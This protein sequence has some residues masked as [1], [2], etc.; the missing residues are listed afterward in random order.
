MKSYVIL[1]CV[2]LMLSIVIF[3]P[4]SLNINHALPNIIDPLFYAWN[5]SHNANNMFGGMNR[6]LN[7]NIFYPLTNTLA[8]SD[9][10]WGQSI[11]TNPIIWLTDNPILAENVAVLISFPLAAISMYLL[12]LYLTRNI[13]ASCISGIFFAFSYPRLSQIGHLPT[14]SS[15]WL[16]LYILY[17]FK[18]LDEGKRINF[19]LLC[20]WYTLSIASSIY[21]G[22]F[23]IPITIII[24]IADFFKRIRT[25]TFY[26]Y[27]NRIIATF[28]SIIFFL[29]ILVVVVF[30]YIRLRVESPELKRSIDDMTHL[31]AAPIDYISIL[32][33]SLIASYLPKRM[34]EHVLYP[35]L[36]VITLAFLGIILTWKRNRYMIVICIAIAVSSVVLS[37]GNERSFSLGSFSTGTLKLPYYYLYK[38]FPILQAVRVPARFGI[39]VILSLS[40]L[41]AWGI[42][43]IM[44]Q[45]HSRWIIGILLCV[46]IIEIWQVNTPFVSVPLKNSIPD[47]YIW[48]RQQ[49]EPMVLAELPVSLFYHG[50]IMEDQLNIP[51]DMLQKS[52]TYAL[53]T[54]RVYF[55]AFHKKRILNGYSGFFTDSYNRLTETLENFPSEDTILTM[56]KIGITHIIVHS[57]QYEPIKRK[58][59]LTLLTY[60]SLISLS[61]SNSNDLVFMIHKKK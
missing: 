7:T 57:M 42:D 59:I 16:P 60:S 47:V 1:F 13:V 22:I 29:I 8:Y 33:T 2:S 3:I 9:T 38:L 11:I 14:I 6:L 21:F 41:A 30:P 55:S 34:N 10:L 28:P 35:T 15:Q 12:S 45:K 40:V 50:K 20:F 27:K 32:P 61:Y 39:F 44:K 36:T 37:L 31:R 24:V 49:P 43:S 51:Y 18:F 26:T 17:L 5:L 48:I 52:D 25:H 4:F 53:E 19:F 23:L 58:E 54:Y 46:F 56:Q